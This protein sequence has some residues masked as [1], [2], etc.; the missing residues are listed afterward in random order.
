MAQDP[1]NFDFSLPGASTPQAVDRTRYIAPPFDARRWSD[2]E[3]SLLVS[4]R[5]DPVR[6]SIAAARMLG[7]CDRFRTLDEHTRHAMAQLRAGPGQNGEFAGELKQLAERGLLLSESA[8]LARLRDVNADGPAAGRIETL[9]VRT[10]HR[11][12]SVR[13]LLTSLADLSDPGH[14]Q[15]CIVLDDGRD[16]AGCKRTAAAV[17]EFR[18]R[19]PLALFHV[20]RGQRRAVLECLA[21]DSNAGVEDLLWFIEGDENDDQPSYGASLN[22]ALLLG[23]GD[24]IAIMDDDA[25]LE[26]YRL[27][28]TDTRARFASAP[29]SRLVFP[30]PDSTLTAGL[31]ALGSSP[32]AEHERHLGASGGDFARH[33]AED[34]R[35]L[36][37]RLDPQMLFELSAPTRIRIT[38]NGT[39]GDPGTSGIQWLFTEPGRNLAALCGNEQDYRRL[40][41]QRRV[42]R[43]P[44]SVQATSVFGLMTTTLTGIDNRDLLLPTQARGGNEDLLFGAMARWLHPGCLHVALPHMLIH[45]RPEPRRWRPEDVDRPRSTNRGRFLADQL[46]RLGADQPA[47]DP[48][49]RI[50]MLRGWLK[51]LASC[52]RGE[53]QWRLQ[54]D[55]L[56][57]RGE[58]I[59]RLRTRLQ[60]LNP[61]PWLA[62]DFRR[63]LA[64]HGREDAADRLRVQALAQDLPGF[65]ARYAAGLT[66]WCR[67][68]RRASAESVEAMLESYDSGAGS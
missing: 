58:T 27:P 65:A 43:S 61:P 48:S 17:A 57:L 34:P 23:A 59:E 25:C 60:E 49:S 3:A 20:S 46:T 15:R 44:D 33:G 19:L 41:G 35:A 38:T 66:S 21:A 28:D 30:D 36:F 56:E 31:Q 52:S 12:E 50:D 24:T 37:E 6:L 32:L 9:F 7:A 55:M 22:F 54:Q 39:L 5:S 1:Y 45:R 8:L 29:S 47:G 68:W 63:A 18:D 13:R 16:D 40:V 67:A 4:H 42:A 62:D 51:G 10:C 64:A 26:A 11:P 53:L 2:N 14:L